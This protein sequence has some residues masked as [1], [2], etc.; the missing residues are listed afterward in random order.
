M[1]DETTYEFIIDEVDAVACEQYE[2]RV[3]RGKT[4]VAVYCIEAHLKAALGLL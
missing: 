4:Y 3:E 2:L 1:T